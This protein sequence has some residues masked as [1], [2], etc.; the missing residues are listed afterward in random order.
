MKFDAVYVSEEE[1]GSRKS[2]LPQKTLLTFLGY[3]REEKS[4]HETR[5]S[6]GQTT[7]TYKGNG[8]Y[9]VGKN[10][11]FYYGTDYYKT[12]YIAPKDYTKRQEALMDALYD[13]FRGEGKDDPV[14]KPYLPVSV[15]E[16]YR[17]FVSLPGEF[18]AKIGFL[19]GVALGV[20][21]AVVSF[22]GLVFLPPIAALSGRS[23]R[24]ASVILYT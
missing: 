13:Q 15:E 12:V 11:T 14:K 8:E 21:W 3:T 1:V 6:G 9:V 20:L 22:Y 7:L 4:R 2:E 5:K 19:I 17:E 18:E 23:H 16:Y 24:A 10:P